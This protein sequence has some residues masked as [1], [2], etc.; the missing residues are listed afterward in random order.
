M[1]GNFEK[2]THHV[3]CVLDDLGVPRPRR[4]DAAEAATAWSNKK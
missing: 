3:L 2:K 1:N 4:A